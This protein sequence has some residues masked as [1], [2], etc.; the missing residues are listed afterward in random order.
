MLDLRGVAGGMGPGEVC[1]AVV[2]A[3]GVLRGWLAGEGGPVVVWTEG[4]VLG[5]AGAGVGAGAGVDGVGVAVWGLVR[6]VQAEF[7]GRVV[8]VDGGCREELA[9]AVGLGEPEVVLEGGAAWVPRLAE[10]VVD[11]S[12][13]VGSGG[14]DGSGVV[15]ITGGLGVLGGVVARHVVRVWG[16]RDVVLLGRGSGGGGGLVA[17]LE[18]LGARVRVVLCDV[19]DRGGLAGVLGDV[20]DVRVVVHAAGVVDDGLLG[21]LTAERVEGVLAAKVVGAWNVHEVGVELGWRLDAFVLFSSLAGVA[22][23]VGQGAYGAGN[24]YLDALAWYRRGLGLPAVS[25][26]WGLWEERSRITAGL[27]VAD[28]ARMERRGVLPLATQ[29]A[30]RLLDTA[31]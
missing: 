6:S 13:E 17:E 7:P 16:A 26:A 22:G 18:A 9:G 23:S 29:D 4:A 20:G 24:A 10:V 5:R 27:S 25:V 2:E 19:A 12:V 15:L 1:G 21:S 31:L 14:W 8:L 30:L 11:G 28:R 3:V